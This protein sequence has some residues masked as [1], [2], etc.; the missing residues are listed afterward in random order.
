MKKDRPN[1]I[2][3]LG[4]VQILGAILLIASLFLSKSQTGIFVRLP[5]YLQ[6]LNIPDYL[7]ILPYAGFLLIIS[8]G[9]LGLKRWG[10][11]LMLSVN[12]YAIITWII[13]YLFF[14]SKL[15]MLNPITSIICVIYIL[16]TK[17]Y[18]YIK[19]VKT[20]NI[21]ETL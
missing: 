12:M 8:F 20:L 11:W 17:R 15:N 21:G 10:Y 1:I 9:Y 5:F 7:F 18:F 14:R 19:P 4:D 2:T 16:P 3:L 13:T 6:V